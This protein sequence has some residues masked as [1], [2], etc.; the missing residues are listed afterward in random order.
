MNVDVY[1]L[2]ASARAAIWAQLSETQH[3]VLQARTLYAGKSQLFN[4]I[5]AR[6]SRW[7]LTAVNIDT[8]WD[9][10]RRNLHA[11]PHY[12]CQ[13]GRVVKYQYVLTGAQP[14]HERLTLGSTHFAQELGI[15]EDVAREVRQKVNQI[16]LYMD[17]VLTYYKWG[18]RFPRARYEAG[19]AAG[20]F[21]DESD[22]SRLLAD[23]ARADFPLFHLDQLRFERIV[24]RALNAAA[25]A[26]PRPPA[27]KQVT[28]RPQTQ[29]ALAPA[30]DW[31]GDSIKLV[32]TLCGGRPARVRQ[33]LA[34]SE[35]AS[36]LEDVQF[37][38]VAAA[39]GVTPP[40]R[41]QSSLAVLGQAN[42]ST[43]EV[44]ALRPAVSRTA[45]QMKQAA[46]LLARIWPHNQAIL[47]TTAGREQM[48]Q[49]LKQAAENDRRK[50]RL[51]TGQ[52]A[53][54][55]AAL[56][57][58]VATQYARLQAQTPNSAAK[59]SL[60]WQA[61]LVRLQTRTLHEIGSGRLG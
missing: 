16:Q 19:L 34:S 54:Y 14:P 3:D 17:E 21:Q 56:D 13:C 20:A 1:T 12:V 35:S 11:H 9:Q 46:P 8:R 28:M 42:V 7:R 26:Q 59:F 32:A 45:V 44:T 6:G 61:T 52:V 5:Y 27:P 33:N 60:D 37:V 49:L 47:A 53:K 31:P 38:A 18:R 40:P 29:V 48:R 43:A 30:S 2:T 10:A 58:R 51:R 22:F 41:L 39:C 55:Q 15:P 57:Q 50:H 36:L 25:P 4:D 23:F 24:T